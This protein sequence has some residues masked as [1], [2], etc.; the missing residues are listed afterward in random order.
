MGGTVSHDGVKSAL[1]SPLEW[2]V[3]ALAIREA[4]E[5]APR[6]GWLAR[7]IGRAT[8]LAPKLPLADPRLD[9]LR[10]FVCDLR[11]RADV[12]D[13][14]GRLRELGFSQSQISAVAQI[15]R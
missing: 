3:V 4:G 13:I 2:K 11:R 9:T 14:A 10:R 15:A 8:G 1:F 5:M 12:S 7:L 6:E